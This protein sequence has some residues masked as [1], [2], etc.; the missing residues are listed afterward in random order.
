MSLLDA[1]PGRSLLKQVSFKTEWAKSELGT[2][3]AVGDQRSDF[4][5]AGQSALE[6]GTEH[7]AEYL[8]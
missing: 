8:L 6:Q 4:K 5:E 2:L 3:R 1:Q 7:K